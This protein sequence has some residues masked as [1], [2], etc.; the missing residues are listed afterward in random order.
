MRRALTF[1]GF[2]ILLVLSSVAQKTTTNGPSINIDYNPHVDLMYEDDRYLYFCLT[3]MYFNEDMYITVYDKENSSVVIHH[4]IDE[5]FLFKTAYMRDNDVVLLG[6]KY[7]TKTKNLE[8]FQSS[9]PVMEKT[10]RKFVKTVVYSVS[11]ENS[12]LLFKKIV[13]SPDRTK[14]AF[15][16]HT[17]PKNSKTKSYSIDVKV[18]STDGTEL[19]KAQ[20]QLNSAP[21]EGRSIYLTND[22]TVFVEEQRNSN[23][24]TEKEPGMEIKAEYFNYRYLTITSNGEIG[25]TLKTNIQ[26]TKPICALTPIGNLRLF[27]ETPTGILILEVDQEGGLSWQYNFETK[28]P[29]EP[30]GITY[31]D[32]EKGL[33][34]TPVQ[35]LTL[36]DGRTLVLGTQYKYYVETAY[37][38]QS[39][40]LFLFDN[41]GNMISQVL[42]YA[43][44][45]GDLRIDH[46][47]A[48]IE[49]DGDIWLI[50]E[51]DKA[52]YGPG[53]ATKWK[54]PEK[55]EDWCIVMGKIED[56]QDFE[57]TLLFT[58]LNNN[59]NREYLMRIMH[60]SDDAVY[61]LK[62]H[63]RGCRIE[64][65]TK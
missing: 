17:R 61:Y 59:I 9:F 36:N 44:R 63:N 55:Q 15:V 39:L 10:P 43:H 5:D 32:H 60:V 25:P 16:T 3:S 33:R 47:T 22:A 12:T 27:G 1:F 11:A 50:Y 18:C 13:W 31:E 41:D 57:P 40:I 26:M 14:M 56:N 29:K 42:P 54:T 6:Y 21:P 58:P 48:L 64:K 38:L 24:S 35:I 46:N 52:N 62:H 4:Q 49:W 23:V 37:S 53:R 7:N 30:K 28:F 2:F 65:I 20:R 34:Y 45:S 51:G 19:M 8:Y